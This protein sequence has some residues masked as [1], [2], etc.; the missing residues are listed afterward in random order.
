MKK[1]LFTVFFVVLAKTSYANTE[2]GKWNFVKDADYCYIGSY[3]TTLDIPEGK[4]RG[5]VYILVYR[6]N[7]S[8]D[9]IIQIQAGYPYDEEKTVDVKIDKMNY[10]FYP[11]EDSAWTDNDSK[12][13]Y[14]MQRGIELKVTGHSKRGTKTT[15]VYTLNGFTA[16]FNKLTNDC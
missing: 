11:N 3:P 8:K 7:K 13:I 15:D 14:A 9:S 4:K 16:A 10:K 1:I 6:I 2:V 12:V 5:D